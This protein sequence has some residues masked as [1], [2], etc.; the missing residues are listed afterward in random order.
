MMFLYY[1]LLRFRGFTMVCNGKTME[2]PSFLNGKT[3]DNQ[4][5]SSETWYTRGG[6]L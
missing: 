2:N 3:M 5:F 6:F 1:G 4:H